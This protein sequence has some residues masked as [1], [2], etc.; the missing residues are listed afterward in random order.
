LWLLSTPFTR[1]PPFFL[2]LFYLK[3]VFDFPFQSYVGC[4]FILSFSLFS[5]FVGAVCKRV[6]FSLQRGWER[7]LPLVFLAMVLFSCVTG[8]TDVTYLQAL[9]L[10]IQMLFPPFYCLTT[11]VSS[12]FVK[13][14]QGP[15]I[16]PCPL[17][18]CCLPFS[19]LQ[20]CGIVASLG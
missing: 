8:L 13:C 6:L 14:L 15:L 19:S 3:L 18:I 9:P 12:V 17:V 5:Y 10:R 20:E 4:L 11:H 7:D 1:S 2:F 16:S